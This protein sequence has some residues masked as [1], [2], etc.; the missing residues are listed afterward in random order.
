MNA[1]YVEITP[2][3]AALVDSLKN[4]EMEEVFAF[5]P[6][7]DVSSVNLVCRMQDLTNYYALVVRRTTWRLIRKA[8]DVDTEL[9]T[10]ATPPE[11]QNGAWGRVRLRCENDQVKAWFNNGEIASRTAQDYSTGSWGVLLIIED[12]NA[13]IYDLYYQSH[14]VWEWDDSHRPGLYG[15]EE[16]GNVLITYERELVEVENSDRLGLVMINRSGAPLAI[17]AN[18]VYLE[19]IDGRKFPASAGSAETGIASFPYTLQPGRSDVDI[20]F[21]DVT[22]SDVTAGLTLVIDL[23]TSGLGQMR[24]HISGQ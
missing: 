21:A 19:R 3:D 8:N 12:E 16:A 11:F 5:P 15:A 1:N 22:Q 6:A 4:M 2:P 10:G 20:A 24:F 9:A 17:A 18:Q 23:S 7:N 13:L 14:R